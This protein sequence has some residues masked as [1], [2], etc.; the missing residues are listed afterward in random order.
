MNTTTTKPVEVSLLMV[1]LRESTAE[2][3][4][5]A[6]R[7]PVQASLVRGQADR[8][9][10]IS[11]LSQLWHVHTALEGE[12]HRRAGAEALAPVKPEQYRAHLA[13]DDLDTLG[14]GMPEAP[15]PVVR[16]LASEAPGFSD[17]E[18]M[19]MHYVL[20]GS[21]NGGRFIAAAVRNGLGLEDRRGTRYLDPYAEAQRARW[22]E[23]CAAMGRLRPSPEERAEMVAGA[24]RMFGLIIEMFDQMA[25]ARSPNA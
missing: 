1:E 19:G 18:L 16:K 25:P 12:L 13:I 17:A 11:Y 9:V 6:E 10:Y 20:E 14:A 7:H 2:L 21:T 3:H 24:T 8:S 15:V 5:R 22:A 23:F 4:T